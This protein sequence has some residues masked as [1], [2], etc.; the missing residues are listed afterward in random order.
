MSSGWDNGDANW[1]KERIGFE[2]IDGLADFADKSFTEA[3]LS[4]FIPERR[5]L[6]IRLDLSME[7]KLV[8][9]WLKRRRKRSS[10]S[11]QEQKTQ[12]SLRA[13]PGAAQ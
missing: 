12:G 6:N 1:I 7:P 8:C 3:G 13:R 2:G 5:V 4:F 9:H 10:T 11:S